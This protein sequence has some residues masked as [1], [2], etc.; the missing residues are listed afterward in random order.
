MESSPPSTKTNSRFYSHFARVQVNFMSSYH[1]CLVF[2]FFFLP[3]PLTFSV[4]YQVDINH[5]LFVKAGVS[6]LSHKKK[7]KKNSIRVPYGV[8]ALLSAGENSFE[9]VCSPATKRPR[10]EKKK[11]GSRRRRR[12]ALMLGLQLTPPLIDVTKITVRCFVPPPTTKAFS[13]P[14]GSHPTW[15]VAVNERASP[16]RAAAAVEVSAGVDPSKQNKHTKGG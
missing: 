1:C 16:P 14:G 10:N 3:T 2:F 7:K 15:K 6:R 4:A 12:S 9:P 8:A 5:S 11:E 13:H